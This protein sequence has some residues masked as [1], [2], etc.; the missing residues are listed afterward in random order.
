MTDTVI[1]CFIERW[2]RNE[3]GAER[4]NFPLFLTELCALLDLPPP[5]P[6]DAT[7][8][9]NDYVFERAVDEI[10]PDGSVR[11]RRIDLYR[12]GCFVLEA[13]QSRERGGAKEVPLDAAQAS[14]P[15]IEP[16]RGRRSAHRGWDVLMRNAREQAELY[17]RC[18][19]TDHG[20][21]PFLLVVDVG[22]AIELFADFSGQ[23]K[24]YRQFPDRAGFR[25]YLDD[26]KTPAIRERLRA[27]WLDPLSLD[28]TRRAARV[29]RDIA[30]RLASVS[31]S[32]EKRGHAAE[33]VAHFLMRCLFT[34]F[35]EGHQLLARGS[36]SGLLAGSIAVP[37]FLPTLLEE[38]WAAMD[39]GT[40]S[41]AVRKKMRRFNGGL[42]ARGRA[43]PLTSAEV[44][45]LHAAARHDWRDVEPAIF[46]TLLEQALDPDERRRLGAHYTPRAY[47]EQLVTATIL[48]PLRDTWEMQVLGTVERLRLTEP[49]AAIRAVH[50]FHEVL[51]NLRVLDPACGTGN[52]LY[53]ALELM[54]RLEGDVLEVLADLGGQ[55]ALALETATV[56]PRQFLGL[57]LNPRAAAIA[58]LVLWLGYLQWQL[59]NRGTIADPVL[60]RLDNI[61]AM[62]AVLAWDGPP[63]A[64][65][66][67]RPDWPAADYIVGN[68]PFIGGK[69]LRVRLGDAY[70]TALWQ[71]HPHMNPSADFVMYWWDRAAALLT[72]PG[73]R[74][75]RF[76]FVTTN[77]ITQ[78]FSRRVIERRMAADP[79]VGLVLAIADH[80]W[81]QA[82]PDAA[83]VRIAMTVAQA[84]RPEGV[85]LAV[86]A[87]AALDSDTPRIALGGTRGRIN[88]DLTIGTDLTAARPL[89]ANDAL[90]SRGMSLHGAGFLVTHDEAVGLGLGRRAGLERHIRPYRNG[91]DLTG[92]SRDLWAIDLFELEDDEAR[93]RFPEVYQHLLR[94][95]RPERA[96]NRRASYRDRWWS[97]GEPR[98][99]LRPALADLPRYIV[100]VETAKHRLFQFLDAGILPDNKLICIA[101]D[102]ACHLGV[103][104]SRIHRAWYLANA[105]MMGVYDRPA[106]YAKTSSFDPF[107]FPPDDEAADAAIAA[108]AEEIDA[109]RREVVAG[110][111]DLTLTGLY[112]LREKLMLGATLTRPE[113]DRRQRGRVDILME[114]H[115][116]LDRAV[117]AAYGWPGDLDDRA[118][119]A[120]LVALNGERLAEE[121]RG[122]VRWLRPDWQRDEAAVAIPSLH[123]VSPETG[124]VRP[125]APR[126]PRPAF[127]RDAIGQ[128]AFVLAALRGGGEM[129]AASIASGFA[130]GRRIERRVQAT[131]EALV[132]LG[133]VSVE[134]SGYRLRRIA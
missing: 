106:V 119:V 51:A 24:H 111:A 64:R 17:A 6:A 95:V 18:L 46:G 99:A 96:G 70:A 32:L 103:L 2:R 126:S 55:E 80:A 112:N 36:F 132:R 62:D 12:R 50:D 67:R 4:A 101:T 45:E 34:M 47:V 79:P 31:R 1:E 83:A 93:R 86:L 48:Q 21:P 73:T 49:Q 66:P 54:K 94:T 52:F 20:W 98:R 122:Q 40:Y 25:I 37:D 121:A 14:L 117:A 84:G 11:H 9:R 129:D 69:D 90:C 115:D 134:R 109:M 42:F 56:H 8:A 61:V 110:H 71:A 124:A 5:D 91:R 76:G 53:V 114:L 116:R 10:A 131:L 15:G 97:F 118:M 87:E 19:P 27:L 59:R 68:P 133:H 63:E 113:Q 92:V 60:E 123:L 88:A 3:G 125:A 26:L 104:Q 13:K 30:G 100:T 65:Q 43:I 127:P 74:L 78:A 44:G 38:L 58:E 102:R 85:L 105:G 33:P 128:T 75:H 41:L 16:P 39:A 72:A 7:R 57:E 107:P 28:P 22:H 81:T 82:T 130:Q 120:R 77:S 89:R 35:A 108:L 29:T 23:G